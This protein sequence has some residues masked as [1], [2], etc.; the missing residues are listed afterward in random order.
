MRQRECSHM[1][2]LEP[3]RP[4]EEGSYFSKARARPTLRAALWKIYLNSNSFSRPPKGHLHR[5]S[6]NPHTPFLE[7]PKALSCFTRTRTERAPQAHVPASPRTVGPVSG[8]PG[9]LWPPRGRHAAPGTQQGRDK[10]L[11]AAYGSSELHCETNTT[12][13]YLWPQE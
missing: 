4:A 10:H 5:I 8:G 2:R 11:L 6:G 9:L 3:W 1:F 13:C 12:K 7:R